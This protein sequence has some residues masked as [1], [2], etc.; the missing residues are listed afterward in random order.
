MT[1]QRR[2]SSVATLSG[3]STASAGKLRKRSIQFSNATQGTFL[4]PEEAA[5]YPTN[6]PLVPAP[7]GHQPRKPKRPE[8]YVARPPNAF[9][10]YRQNA[11]RSGL[12]PVGP[13]ASLSKACGELWHAEP[14][15]EKAYWTAR[16]KAEA[17]SHA[18]KYPDYKYQPKKNRPTGKQAR[19]DYEQTK[20]KK[21]G[22]KA[23]SKPA[24]AE[25]ASAD[26]E[27]CPELTLTLL[28]GPKGQQLKDAIEKLDR[29]RRR[30]S[31]PPEFGLSTIPDVIQ[32]PRRPS[33]AMD[34]SSESMM[35]D[36]NYSMGPVPYDY[37]HEQDLQFSHY[38]S[39]L[40]QMRPD[41]PV[42]TNPFAPRSQS[43]SSS[44]S[45]PSPFG[46]VSPLDPTPLIYERR[47]SF[48]PGEYAEPFLTPSQSYALRKGSLEWADLTSSQRFGMAR[49][50]IDAQM[51]NA[52]VPT[53]P[54]EFMDFDLGN[55]RYSLS[56]TEF[57][58]LAQ[59]PGN[60]FFGALRGDYGGMEVGMCVAPNDTVSTAP[61]PTSSY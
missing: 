1:Q 39:P 34:Y 18:A 36:P 27:E 60:P 32:P 10:L 40:E 43:T 45:A 61:S 38:T 30:S 29:Q 16:A 23:S 49:M 58:N 21:G 46:H 28:Q 9:I 37:R 56:F 42:F 15:K 26:N 17:A 55:R 22:K 6:I 50:S 54:N 25:A 11:V 7:V 19:R 51:G 44:S 59:V 3:P 8:G 14:P 57:D 4:E 47:P 12:V 53:Q 20:S 2:R 31:V 5:E 48:S 41:M 13:A 52:F 24:P 33:S 35:A